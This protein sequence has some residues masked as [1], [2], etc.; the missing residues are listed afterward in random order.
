V[1]NLPPFGNMCA[2]LRSFAQ[3][4]A[5]TQDVFAHNQTVTRNLLYVLGITVLVGALNWLFRN[6][7]AIPSGT[8]LVV[9]LLV[10]PLLWGPAFAAIHTQ[11]R[12]LTDAVSVLRMHA[13]QKNC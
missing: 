3:E 10:Y 9:A 2:L 13:H 7:P 5:G 8:Q 4:L 11:R 12:R 6:T 1:L